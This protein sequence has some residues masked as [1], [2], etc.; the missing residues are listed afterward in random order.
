M[1]TTNKK[2]K[3][4]KWNIVKAYCYFYHPFE[5]RIHLRKRIIRTP[6]YEPKSHDCQVWSEQFKCWLDFP[7][8]NV[9]RV[10]ELIHMQ[11]IK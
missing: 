8:P 2:D 10:Y 9:C 1:R 5:D 7:L 6:A 3:Q 4:R 11:P